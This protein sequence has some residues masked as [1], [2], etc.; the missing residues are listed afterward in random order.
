M[1]ARQVASRRRKRSDVEVMLIIEQHASRS[2]SHVQRQQ[3]LKEK[4]QQQQQQQQKK[5]KMY[6]WFAVETAVLF[7]SCSY[8]L[9]CLLLHTHWQLHQTAD[10]DQQAFSAV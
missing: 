5:K 9:S 6:M 10:N 2:G 7:K 1:A 4:Q 8:R 3:V